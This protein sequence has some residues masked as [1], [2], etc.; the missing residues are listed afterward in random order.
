M[1]NTEQLKS[2]FKS[3]VKSNIHRDGIED[4]LNWLET[5]DFYT[6]PASTRS[7]GSEQS[8]L[9]A[10]SIAVYKYAKSFQEFESD[11]SIAISALFHD[12]CKV[13]LYKQSMRNV[14]DSTG[15][16]VQVPYYEY[17]EHEEL[18]IGHGEKSVI[19]LQKYMKLTDEE[20][21]A[22]RWHMG[23]FYSNNLHEATS[24]A[25]ALAKY[26]LVLKLQTADKAAAFWDNV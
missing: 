9:L 21:C 22:I 18:P 5:T 16:W 26:K 14:K 12:L 24:V 10:H 19:I 25:N 3:I 2:E 11:E 8:G 13:N 6:A 23:G 15:K 20:I 1:Y 4:L 7:H 17:D